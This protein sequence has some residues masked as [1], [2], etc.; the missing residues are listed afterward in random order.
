MFAALAPFAAMLLQAA[1]PGSAAPAD[2]AS[3]VQSKVPITDK[4]HPEY[5]RCKTE[6][7][8]G[9][10]AKRTKTCKTNREWALLAQ[11]GNRLANEMIGQPRVGGS[12]N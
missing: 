4:T 2:P 9:S 10:R 5:V 1:V 8:L 3:T 12:G 11:Q 6:P 7:V